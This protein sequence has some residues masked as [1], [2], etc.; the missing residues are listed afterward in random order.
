[1]CPHVEMV[2]SFNQWDNRWTEFDVLA[3]ENHLKQFQ[4]ADMLSLWNFWKVFVQKDTEANEAIPEDE[5][6]E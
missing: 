4:C 3:A 6:L 5:A 2:C 1:M